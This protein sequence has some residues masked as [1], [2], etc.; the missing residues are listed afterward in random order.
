MT[1]ANLRVLSETTLDD[2][3]DRS[4]ERFIRDAFI[5]DAIDEYDTLREL[6][7][8]LMYSKIIDGN[9]LLADPK[10]YNQMVEI[11]NRSVDT[12]KQP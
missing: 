9:A 7:G 8:N 2:F 3:P 11:F 1:I 4:V 5:R 10:V 6:F 12:Q